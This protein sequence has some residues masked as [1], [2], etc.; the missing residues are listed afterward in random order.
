MEGKKLFESGLVKVVRC[1]ECRFSRLLNA[2]ER[3]IYLPTVLRCT[4]TKMNEN[5]GYVWSHD[6]CSYGER[7]DEE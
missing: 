2:V 6:Y 7:M 4:C 1:R 3:E 5:G